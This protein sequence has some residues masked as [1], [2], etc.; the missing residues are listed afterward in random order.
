MMRFSCNK[1]WQVA[2]AAGEIGKRARY[3]LS[4]KRPG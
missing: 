3:L 1:K 2:G 4:D